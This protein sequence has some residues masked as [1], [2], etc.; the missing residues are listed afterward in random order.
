M[1]VGVTAGI[2]GGPKVS[3]IMTA[4]NAERF[5]DASVR[6]AL[7]QDYANFDVVLLDDGSTDATR[8]I[9]EKIESARFH[10]VRRERMGR[11]KALNEAIRSSAGEYIAINDADDL[12]FPDR[13]SYTLGYLRN[14]PDV[15]VAATQYVTADHFLTKVPDD[16]RRPEKQQNR[17][18]AQIGAVRLYRSNPLV[19]S[20]V[21]FSRRL[22]KLVD[23]YDET[24]QMCIDYD[25]Y[26]RSIRHGSIMLL[27]L[28]TVIYFQNAASFF[29]TS[30]RLDYLRTLYGVRARARETLPMPM[31]TRMFDLLPIYAVFKGRLIRLMS[32]MGT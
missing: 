27:P 12:S 15:A 3:M 32:N 11:S 18:A 29:K 2:S 10:Y 17:S 9:C 31:W 25:F 8:S 4:F 16:L 6:A 23:G 19:H 30:S 26:L 28:A 24:L 13:I 22:W 14:N 7:D 5:I 20:T 1:D 21:M